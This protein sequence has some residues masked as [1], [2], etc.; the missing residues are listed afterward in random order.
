MARKLPSVKKSGGE[1]KGSAY[2]KEYLK[3]KFDPRNM[4]FSGGGLGSAIGRSVFGKGYSMGDSYKKDGVKAGSTLSSPTAGGAFSEQMAADAQLTAKNTMVLPNMARD[5]NI[6]KLNIMKLVKQGGDKATSGTD[7]FWK[8][9]GGRESAYE[10]AIAKIKGAVGIKSG[11]A[12][13][14]VKGKEVDSENPIPVKVV[15]GGSDM[16]DGITS[17]FKGN[18]LR[19]LMTGVTSVLTSPIFL[20]ST[21]LFLY[22]T[23]TSS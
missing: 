3:E 21:F 17:M 13:L 15:E 23:L 12:G 11:P 22:R 19:S 1:L 2:L 9:A 5:M 20:I 16:E 10:S 8:Q 7:M 18:A 6:M 14:I 4:L